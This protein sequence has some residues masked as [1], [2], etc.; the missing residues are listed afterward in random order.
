MIKI[1]A[2]KPLEYNYHFLSANL[3]SVYPFF[4]M[5][6][7]A[8]SLWKIFM[9]PRKVLW[10]SSINSAY[11]MRLLR[12]SLYFIIDD[13]FWTDWG[14]KPYIRKAK[15]YGANPTTIVETN[16]GWPNGLCVDIEESRIYWADAKTDRY[17]YTLCVNE[18]C[19]WMP[20]WFVGVSSGKNRLRG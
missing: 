20:W 6:Y 16:L 12:N 10:L 9:N 11:F 8:F 18:V 14:R 15:S 1:A 4:F 17:M 3:K 13:M 7:T 5:S 19:R 2:G